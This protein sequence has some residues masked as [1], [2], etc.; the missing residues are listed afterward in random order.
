MVEVLTRS[1]AAADAGVHGAVTAEPE[2]QRGTSE[3]SAPEDSAPVA[4]LR[5][6]GWFPTGQ[7]ASGSPDLDPAGGR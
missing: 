6:A 2:R 3:L 1:R 5:A 4:V 7:D